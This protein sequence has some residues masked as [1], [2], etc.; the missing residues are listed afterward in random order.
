M[1]RKV[2]IPVG[3]NPSNRTN[4]YLNVYDI[5]DINKYLYWTGLG[6]HHSRPRCRI[7]IRRRREWGLLRDAEE[8]S[9]V[10]IPTPDSD[11]DDQLECSRVSKLHGGMCRKRVSSEDVSFAYEQLQP[12][13]RPCV[14]EA[15]GEGC[16][17]M[18]QSAG[19]V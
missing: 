12:F 2:A 4:V 7:R 8:G 18:G 10:L 16:S 19:E 17:T 5:G 13:Y 1:K 15:H 9:G 3:S 14:S 6:V 11:G